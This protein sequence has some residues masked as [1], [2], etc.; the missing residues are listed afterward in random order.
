MPKHPGKQNSL[1]VYKDLSDSVKCPL[2]KR[3]VRVVVPATT[4]TY[5]VHGKDD[6]CVIDNQKAVEGG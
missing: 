6:L 4:F 3:V 1:F 2:C 5:L